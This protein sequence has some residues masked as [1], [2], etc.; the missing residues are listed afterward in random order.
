MGSNKR[1]T[2][3]IITDDGN[4]QGYLNLEE[5]DLL[6][7]IFQLWSQQ[8]GKLLRV[9]DQ[10]LL[11]RSLNFLHWAGILATSL[12]NKLLIINLWKRGGAALANRISRLP[13]WQC[14][15]L[16]IFSHI[17]SR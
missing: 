3:T 1:D 7:R 13:R 6:L 15:A 9:L 10:Q 2:I 11:Y 16:K 12:A 5:E 4:C 17:I 8:L 14:R